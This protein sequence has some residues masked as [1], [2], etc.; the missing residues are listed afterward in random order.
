[1]LLDTTIWKLFEVLVTHAYIYIL[2]FIL[3]K[4]TNCIYHCD[5]VI[6]FA[7]NWNS[8][9]SNTAKVEI[10]KL[11]HG[12]EAYDLIIINNAINNKKR[13]SIEK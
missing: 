1:M 4:F 6:F 10:R 5:K 11:G 8:V 2:N 7:I 12:Q 13:F 9:P 3:E